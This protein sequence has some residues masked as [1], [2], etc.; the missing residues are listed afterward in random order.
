MVV[1]CF[2]SCIKAYLS[3]VFF[4]HKYN[5]LEHPRGGKLFSRGG[6]C[7]PPKINP[8]CA[9]YKLSVLHGGSI[10]ASICLPNLVP[11]GDY[12]W[13][14]EPILAAKIGPGGP[15]LGDLILV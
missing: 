6:K 14:W 4:K 2:I 15:I 3:A 7:P 11:L 8:A 12:F 1:Y 13:Q 10:L 5:I 9:E